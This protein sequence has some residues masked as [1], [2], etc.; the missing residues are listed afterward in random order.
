MLNILHRLD[1][2]RRLGMRFRNQRE[3]SR[4]R[5]RDTP[6]SSAIADAL[7]AVLTK[8]VSSE[9]R[10][11][12]DRIEAIR[13]ELRASTQPLQFMDYGA[14]SPAENR[15]AEEMYEGKEV[16]IGIAEACAA[17]KPPLWCLL[18]F[19]LIRKMRPAHCLEL[20]TNL[21][22]SAAYLSAALQLNGS[23]ELVTLEGARSK[24]DLA[25]RNFLRLGLSRVS[26]VVGRFQDKL[27]EVLTRQDRIDFAFID[28]HHDEHAT[29]DYFRKI[30]P[31]ARKDTVL[32]FDDIAWSAG[33][34]RAWR[35][36]STDKRILFAVDLGLVGLC[37]VGEGEIL[38]S[39]EQFKIRI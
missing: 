31:F 19:M 29:V 36:I 12:I 30:I 18:L 1:V 5:T 25:A 21:G 15:N 13:R 9:E 17:S 35:T 3:L 28:G 11:W 14:G 2:T 33:M 39:P 34:K 32:V 27:D 37:V 10:R 23:G 16:T 24:A 7:H 8:T 6:A 4:L 38:G 26:V 20:G 22:V